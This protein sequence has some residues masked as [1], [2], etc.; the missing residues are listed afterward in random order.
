MK[1]NAL[2]G[3]ACK[4]CPFLLIMVWLLLLT[5]CAVPDVAATRPT[6]TPS[7]APSPTPTVVWFPPTATPSPAPVLPTPTPLNLPVQPEP[8]L[9]DGFASADNWQIPQSSAGSVHITNNRLTLTLHQSRF[10]ISTL[11]SQP[12]LRDFYLQVR[13]RLSLCS[14]SDTYGVLFRVQSPQDFYRLSLNCQQQ[15][16]LDRVQGGKR[17][18]LQ[19]PAFSAAAPPRPPAEATI[20]I[21]A[22]G[23]EISVYLDGVWQFTVRDPVFAA[24][25]IGFDLTSDLSQ[26]VTILFEDLTVYEL[27][28]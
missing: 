4:R 2:P 24:G 14:G 15:I 17:V 6:A 16:R 5:A 10:R 9:K 8:L 23:G 3:A 12:V 20:G 28:P 11:R 26:D 7:P 13:V 21:L 25:L 19:P 1:N 27:L 22:R 18:Y